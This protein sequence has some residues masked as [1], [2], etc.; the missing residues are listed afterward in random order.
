[1][2][3]P[4]Y[5][6]VPL[7]RRVSASSSRRK[8]RH[9]SPLTYGDADVVVLARHGH[10]RRVVRGQGRR[11]GRGA[12][13]H[14]VLAR[15]HLAVVAGRVLARGQGRGQDEEEQEPDQSVASHGIHFTQRR[16]DAG[17]PFRPCRGQPPRRTKT[18]MDARFRRF[19]AC[20]PAG[21]RVSFRDIRS[22]QQPVQPRPADAQPVRRR[23][24][25]AVH[26]LQHGERRRP[27]D[28]VQRGG[29]RQRAAPVVA[30]GGGRGRRRRGTGR[31]GGCRRRS[32]AAR[33]P[34]RCAARAR[35]PATRAPAAPAA[36]PAPARARPSRTAPPACEES[37][38]PAAAR[39]R[40][41]RAGGAG[42]WG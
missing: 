23:A 5:I 27:L 6:R 35:C 20:V 2:V 14:Q 15:H 3:S 13:E 24:L 17:C 4:S 18:R 42:G 31:P 8:R 21:R 30:P 9:S 25:V 11:V 1:M 29:E 19:R 22:L 41:G 34:A 10:E 7:G 16:E 32:A 33:A 38:P 40:R 12:Q 36:A 37:A 28:L 26:P 39:R